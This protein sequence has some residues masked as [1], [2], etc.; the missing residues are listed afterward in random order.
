MAKQL[1]LPADISDLSVAKLEELVKHHNHLYWDLNAPELPDTDYDRLILRLK[2][3]SP[4]SQVLNELGPSQ[5]D[6]AE[7]FG[8][9][10]THE[11]PMLSLDKCY[12]D[13]DLREW[14][15]TFEGDIVVSP[16]FDG[17]AGSLH[18]DEQGR[19][20]LAS[21]RGNGVQGD[22]ITMNVRAM[23]SLPRQLKVA[24][25]RKI[26]VRGELYMP[27]S[28]FATFKDKFANPRNL[29]AGAIKQKDSKKSAAYKIA[30]AA[31]D[32]VGYELTTER[33]KYEMLEKLGFSPI[34]KMFVKRD[35]V[36][37]A[38][39]TF[40]EK[41]PTLDY[42]ID[43]VVFK[44]DL[45]REH[46]RLGNTSH[47][48][49]CAIAYK[50]QGDTGT[51]IL[52]DIEWSVARTGVITP[53]ALVDPVMLSGAMVGRA[54]L[55]HAGFIK[56]LGVTK[57]AEVQM[58][59]RGGVIPNLE[60][61]VKAGTEAIDLPTKC[62]S[63]SSDV[64]ADGDFIFCSTPDQCRSAVMGQVLHFVSV[65][66]VDGFGD[67]IVAELYDR[68]LVRSPADL[69]TLK[70]E[71]LLPIERVGEKLA[72]KL[73][74]A[75]AAKKTLPLGL[76]LRSLGVDELGKHVSKILVDKFGTLEK[77]LELKP[78][79]LSA[80]HSIGETIAKTVVDGLKL[81]KPRIDAL[82]VHV[83]LEEGAAG[84]AV[85]GAAS[86]AVATAGA[87]STGPFVGKSFVFTGKMATLDRNT[88]QARVRSLGGD[89]PDSVN[90]TIT[91]LVVGDD[92]S[93]TSKSSKE[94]TAD[95]L[96]AGGAPIKI[97]SETDFLAMVAEAEK[98]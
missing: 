98:P 57:G 83:T 4:T 86:T 77:V 80:I 65:I 39:R 55:H 82:L 36:V 87:A 44:A 85:G 43:G 88:A 61:V 68:K 81:A 25:G 29:A 2:E 11:R 73:V 41:R 34:F 97:I 48:P 50:F 92:K 89:T 49:R 5:D 26:E 45:L 22:D 13:D 78:E 47:H 56:K 6:G 17:I 7:R 53:V 42:E 33:E 62:P 8:N 64:R 24:P 63:C 93:D 96:I 19:L 20:T 51:S 9:P 16:K 30:F 94:K 74:A 52:R 18:F 84:A 95:K 40:A 76:F 59:R 14:V 72:K 32:L 54:S 37:D 46:V 28:V 3:L 75:M 38:Y 91:H 21:T 31:Y 1:T 35:E 15:K 90:K 66:D 27:L 10:V 12:H 71:D 70:V 67:R 79:D 60:K 23:D 69:Y 58:V